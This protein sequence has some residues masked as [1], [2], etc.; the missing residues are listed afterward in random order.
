M[1]DKVKFVITGKPKY[2]TMVRLAIGSI[3]DADGFNV[4]EIDD[5]KMAVGEACKNISCH[6]KEGM[7]AQYTVECISDENSMEIYVTDTS[8]KE[9]LKDQSMKCID[10]PNEG[11]IGFYVIKS[12]MTEAEIIETEAG[13]KTIKMVKRK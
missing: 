5:I 11:D 6:G 8:E 3:A 9:T 7:A 13:N 2:I 1:V 10:C 12:L 4:D